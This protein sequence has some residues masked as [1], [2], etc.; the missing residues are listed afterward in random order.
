MFEKQLDFLA[1]GDIATDAF[2][3][4][5]EAHVNC[6]LDSLA[7]EICLKFADK[8]PFESVTIVKAVGNSAN[9]AVAA[10]RL[11][12]SAAFV[13]DIGNDQNGADC[14][15]NLK[16]ERVD[17]HYVTTH[18][19][20]ETNYHYVLWYGAERTILVN[21]KDYP[22][23]LPHIAKPPRWVYLSSLGSNSTEYHE[24]ILAYLL[25]H[26][27][28]RLAFQPGTFQMKLGKEKLAALYKR[29]E[30]FVCNVEEAERILGIPVGPERR[31]IKKL[32]LAL[33]ALG[34]RIVSITD[35]PK[36]AYCSE[37]SGENFNA[38]FMPIYP[39]PKPPMERTGAGD[40]FASTLVSALILGKPLQEALLWA[41]INS[42]WVVQFVGAQEGL[43]TKQGLESWLSHAP[44]NYQP[45]KI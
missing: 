5:K 1:I 33:H 40:A 15:M 13:T 9:A 4:L 41:P 32:L 12:L 11:G 43:L 2:I 31:D 25:A 42:M 10:S 35:G 18:R 39:D 36:G 37:K 44:A 3:R 24:E 29:T 6:R 16:K 26:P 7:C 38:W 20:M 23:H 21:H 17:T 14:V 27:Q 19:G 30:V 34:P 28:V 22:Y 8:V 45:V